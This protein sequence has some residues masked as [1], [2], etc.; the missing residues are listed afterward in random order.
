MVPVLFWDVDTQ[1][2]F[3]SPDGKLYVEG[4]D[5]LIPNLG[6]LTRAAERHD[7]P[8]L[9]SADDHE[10][11]DAEISDDP[12]FEE[13][14]PP[15]CMRGTAGA[16]RVPATRLPGMTEIGHHALS[17]E[18]LAEVIA[19]PPA[20]VLIHKKRFDV[21][22]NV[23]TE[24]LLA[25]ID[26]ARIVIYGVALDVCN[27]YAIEG[28]LERG[29]KGLSLV[30]DATQAIQPERGE[31]LK[32]DWEAQGVS[33]TTTDAVLDALGQPVGLTRDSHQLRSDK[34]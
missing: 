18:E 16:E 3:L 29:R 8:V 4:S 6:R 7:L 10:P 33:L 13:T 22:S 5:R 19:P 32:A 27:R 28:L 25:A 2:D 14:F 31:R 34:P 26:P 17:D 24:R 21:F 30:V 15:H 12:D 23:N 20:R 11:G 9:A 1:V